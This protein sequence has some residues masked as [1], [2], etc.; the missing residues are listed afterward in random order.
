MP[1]L[2]ELLASV[3]PAVLRPCLGTVGLQLIPLLKEIESSFRLGLPIDELKRRLWDK[4]R[5]ERML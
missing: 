2:K 1:Q 3:D 5:A 4:A